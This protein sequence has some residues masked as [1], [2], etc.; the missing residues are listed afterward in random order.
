MT[1]SSSSSSSSQPVRPCRIARGLPRLPLSSSALDASGRRRRAQRRLVDVEATATDWRH[2][3][4]QTRLGLRAGLHRVRELQRRTCSRARQP[5]T[6]SSFR[7][8]LTELRPGGRR[9]LRCPAVRGGRRRPVY[10]SLS[11]SGSAGRRTRRVQIFFLVVTDTLP[12]SPSIHPRSR[13]VRFRHRT[14]P[15]VAATA[16]AAN[17]GRLRKPEIASKCFARPVPVLGLFRFLFSFP[18]FPFNHGCTQYL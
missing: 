12:L 11:N 3:P 2:V 4:A 10:I 6:P 7:Y 1:A 15:T 13:L 16:D 14:E 8:Q 17:S 5:A 9:V 18:Y